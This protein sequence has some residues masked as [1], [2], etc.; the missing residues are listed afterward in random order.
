MEL[1]RSVIAGQRLFAAV[2]TSKDTCQ[3]E[4]TE[5]ASINESFSTVTPTTV[6]V[7]K[8]H[9]FSSSLRYLGLHMNGCSQQFFEEDSILSC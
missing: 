3:I 5:T 1:K 4:M 2:I 7:Q 6:Y 8:W 9:Q